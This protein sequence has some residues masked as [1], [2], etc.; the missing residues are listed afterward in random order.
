MNRRLLQTATFLLILSSFVAAPG[1]AADVFRET[2]PNGLRVVIVRNTLAPAVAVEVNYL[3]GSNEAPPGMPGMA[4]AQ[5]H[6][7]FRGS[8][9]LSAAQL[10]TIMA[11]MGG[12]F[13][14]DTQQTVTQYF[15]TVPAAHLRTALHIESIRMQSVLDTN[16]LWEQ[17][18][19]AIEQEVA[20]D[21]SN[22][23]YIFYSRLLKQVFA[24]TP[25]ATDALG[26]RA[27]FEKTT[28]A[29]L[30]EFHR[31]WYAPNNAILVIT[32]DVEPAETI[33]MVK[34][35][36]GPIPSSKLPPRPAVNLHEMKGAT[37]NV[38]T[39]LGYG[40]AVVAYRLPG[41]NDSDA[42]ATQVL[43]DALGSERGNL[44]ALGAEGKAL[45]STF[46]SSLF[47]PAG[48]GFALAAYPKGD[49]GG[50]MLQ[51]LKGI[52]ADYV[53][54][55]VPQSLVEAAKRREIAESAFSRNS[56]SGLAS[57]WSDALAVEGR[58]SPQED[59]DAISRVTVE[60]V[61][62]VARKYLNNDTAVVALLVPRVSGAAT[63][64]NAQFGKESFAPRS[65][66]PVE[67]PEWARQAVEVPSVPHSNLSPTVMTLPNGLRL[68]VQP[69]HIS[70]TI[71]LTGRIRNNPD[72]QSPKGEEGVSSV[73]S[74]LFDYG[75]ETKGR[76]A[77]QEALDAI[78]ADES[79]GTSFSLQV[80]ADKFDRGTELLAENLLHPA[81]PA[82]AFSIVQHQT[83]ASLK[84]E[85]VSPGHR[86]RVALEK[87]LYPKGDPQLREAT[88]ESVSSLTL[89]LV[90]N[91]YNGVF[92]PDMTTI[93]VAG[94]TTPEQARSIV[95]KYFGGWKASGPRPVTLLPAVPLNK[96]AMFA[97]PDKSRVQDMV[98]LGETVE[99]K[100]ADPVYYTLQLGNHVLAG[101]FY[102]SRL[103]RDLR[104]EA[105]LVY[106]VDAALDAG[107]TR[108]TYSVI[109]ASDPGNVSKA[110]A[111][112]QRDLGQ[113]QS[114]PVSTAELNR[115]KTLLI[116]RIPLAESSVDAVASG[117]LGRAVDDLPLDEPMR[118][119][120]RYLATTPGQ[121][122]DA[123][124]KYIRPAGFAEVT[125]GPAPGK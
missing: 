26:T 7:M 47:P 55:G 94:D 90:K 1:R 22:P 73:L 11:A 66:K 50:K 78:G 110:R 87:A 8:Q 68:I 16:E 64:G 38:E 124:R 85:L 9:G 125:L 76:I 81:L 72:I 100:R 63:A 101:G 105:G 104:E 122:R 75:T 69:E 115:A 112:I 114:A 43:S 123:F 118:A 70:P 93:V 108:T 103:Y 109:Y 6:M 44:F 120:E 21:L 3:V 24:D 51:T 79:A 4:H 97:V 117:L 12:D 62:R 54:N 61:N 31:K 27:S 98:T 46:E 36:F 17:E 57:E 58:Q 39:D 19:G 89:P 74:Q 53:R 34:E 83:E 60:D 116:N 28:G 59:V 18:R 91:Y 96:P 23:E 71:T 37:I 111:M 67:V 15:M 29:M 30:Q 10:S 92:R 41:Y 119:A 20:Q 84:G 106:S 80:L 13:N 77:F 40:L 33:D 121:V 42:A 5:E 95:E 35:L 32:G 52:V 56:I 86:A 82:S 25:Y 99:I 107:R 49:D 2:L 65:T 113:I 88:P 14:A 102:A 45:G 48:I